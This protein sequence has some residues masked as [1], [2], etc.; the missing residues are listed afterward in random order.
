MMKFPQWNN[1]KHHETVYIWM[2]RFMVLYLFWIHE[3][4]K[5]FVELQVVK[6][7]FGIQNFQ[8]IPFHNF[9]EEAQKF[10][11]RWSAICT[12]FARN[13]KTQMS[14]NPQDPK[15]LEKIQSLKD[16]KIF[17]AHEY[18]GLMSQFSSHPPR[19]PAK[20]P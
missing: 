15:V 7:K 5:I 16:K 18:P 4:Y 20:P 3:I 17:C 2:H 11:N 9:E 1:T 6:S 13:I 8:G 10:K 19:L 12:V 14:R